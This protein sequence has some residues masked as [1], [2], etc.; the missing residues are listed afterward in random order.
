MICIYSG[1]TNPGGSTVAF[2]NLTNALNNAG[3]ETVFMGSHTWPMNKC[4]FKLVQD[5]IKI[6]KDDVFIVHFT[7][8]IITR[9]QVKK[10]IFSCHEQNIF[11]LKN[12]NYKIFDKIHFVSEHQKQFHNIDHPSFVIPNILDDLK[13]NPKPKQKIAGIIGSIDKNKQTHISIMRA[14]NDGFNQIFIFGLI[15]DYVYWQNCV[16][17]LIKQNPDKVFYKGFIEDKQQMYDSITD[18]YFSSESECLPYVIG[19]CI[20]TNTDIHCLSNK[21]Y[22]NCVY[23]FDANKICKMWIDEINK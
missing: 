23:E 10:L 22:L 14:L 8:K 18:V 13:P 15:T 19:E 1:W 7:N 3:Y 2:I 11:P 20:K 12:I 9:P 17:P 21:N 6:N 4:R 5:Y 16:F